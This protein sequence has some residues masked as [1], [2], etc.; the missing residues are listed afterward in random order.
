MTLASALTALGAIAKWMPA[1]EASEAKP[2]HVEASDR[3]AMAHATKV[4]MLVFISE[5]AC[6]KAVLGHELDLV[7]SEDG[8]GADTLHYVR[9]F[10][11]PFNALVVE[12]ICGGEYYHPA[13]DHR[14]GEF[15]T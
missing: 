8:G 1:A 2:T 4:F 10:V 14:I 6:S 11:D 3:R 15:N 9:N 13:D 12:V 5:R 7:A